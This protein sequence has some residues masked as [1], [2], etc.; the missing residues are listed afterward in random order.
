[1]GRPAWFLRAP[2]PE[3]SYSTVGR[4]VK[5]QHDKVDQARAMLQ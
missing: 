4:W 1:M 2:Y 5:E 3:Y